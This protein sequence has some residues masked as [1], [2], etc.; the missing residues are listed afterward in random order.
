M[1]RL[2][3]DE[4]GSLS[5]AIA[6]AANELKNKFNIIWLRLKSKSN[7]L[8]CSSDCIPLHRH[9][10]K[11]I[12]NE[13]ELCLLI[14]SIFPDDYR[15][16][17]EDL[18]IYGMGLKLFGD[19]HDMFVAKCGVHHLISLINKVN[20]DNIR[21][22]H[23][24]YGTHHEY[25]TMLIGA[26]DFAKSVASSY[27]LVFHGETVIEKWPQS[28]LYKDCYGLLLVLKKIKEHP[29]NMECPK[30]WLLLLKYKEDSRSIPVDFFERMK[31]LRVLSLDVSSLPQSLSGLKNLRTLRLKVPKFEDM[32]WIGGLMNLEF[33]SISTLS[34]TD[35]PKEMR[36]LENLR[37]L[38]LRKMNLAYIPVGVLSRMLKLEELYLP[39][40]FRRWGC[41]AKEEHDDYDECESRKEDNYDDEEGINARTG[42]IDDRKRTN[43]SLTEILSLSLHALQITI[44]KASILPKKS[45]IFKNIQHFKVIVPNY[46]KYQPFDKDSMNHLQLMGDS[47][48]IKESGICDLM[49]RTEYLSLTRVRNLKNVIFQLVDNDFP[50]LKKMIISECDELE[51]VVD[52][53][54]KQISPKDNCSFWK[55]DSLHLSMLSNLKEICHGRWTNIQWFPNLSQ[56]SIRFCHKLKYVFPLS[57]VGG[58]KL[59]KSIEILDCNEMEGIFNQGEEDD[60]WL[61]HYF[62]EELDLHSLPKLIGLLVQK[63]NTNNGVHVDTNQSLPTNEIVSNSMEESISTFDGHFQSF[64]TNESTSRLT[65]SC[66]KDEELICPPPTSTSSAQLLKSVS[67]EQISLTKSKDVIGYM[68][69]YGALIPSKLAEKCLQNL[70]RLKIAFCDAVKVIFLFEEN[71]ATSRAFN[72]LKVLELHGLRNLV[73]IWFQTPQKII[74]FQ[75]LQ[76]LILLECHNLYLFSSRVAKLLVQLQKICISRCKMMGEIIVLADGKEVKDK[77][78]FP[79]LKLL[80]LQHMHNLRIFCGGS[81]DIELPLLETLKF[82]QCNKMKCFSYGSLRTP[83][84]ERVQI[85]GSLMKI[86][87]DLNET[88][89]RFAEN[90]NGQLF[91]FSDLKIATNNFIR[92]PAILS[93][94][95]YFGKLYLGWIDEKT[96]APSKAGTGMAVAIKKLKSESQKRLQEWKL[97]VNLLE[98]KFHRNI[99]KLLGHCWK[100]KELF[101]VYEFM[102]R[103]SLEDHLLSSRNPLIETLS[104]DMRLKIAIGIARG[105][106][107]LHT[108]EPKLT[109]RDI[110]SSNI[111]LDRLSS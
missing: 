38:D 28:N 91:T 55:L 53:T 35:I 84:L 101:L 89:M 87:G 45:Q 8:A 68:E 106:D 36:Q 37:V 39:L 95:G 69:M 74:A 59:L 10:S 54:G 29:L 19:V 23:E 15:I 88:M 50:Q 56:I 46:L 1:E 40:N 25:V 26:R 27:P 24:E 76:I 107:F 3:T 110:N 99:V 43:A 20:G 12:P 57:I 70:R 4:H 100:D 11:F 42:E 31:E 13:A 73:H 22:G 71:H 14:C 103:G 63:D 33:L 65:G 72:S 90:R 77:I 32:S 104:W 60:D 66:I 67:R 18:V 97:E 9:K 41:K 83:M 102:E 49:S 52:T 48:D 30:L 47:S 5:V 6:T 93:D 17:I 96:F 7:D 109:H 2:V 79:Q 51:C 86:T 75:N 34:L 82:N 92:S 81:Y 16:P 98:R 21:L 58:L 108:S 85:N 111:L 62:I 44:P 80:E 94:E 64:S 105:L 61:V 78:V